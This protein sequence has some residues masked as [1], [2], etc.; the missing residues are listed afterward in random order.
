[1]AGNEALR[2]KHESK[3]PPSSLGTDRIAMARFNGVATDGATRHALVVGDKVLRAKP[4]FLA[5]RCVPV[6]HV[7]GWCMVTRCSER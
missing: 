3:L 7:N 6:P 1:M 5:S 4:S 2:A